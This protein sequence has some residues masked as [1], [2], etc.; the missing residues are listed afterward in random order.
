MTL[1]LEDLLMCWFSYLL[2]A[3]GWFGYFFWGHAGGKF[4]SV[5]HPRSQATVG[6]R[7]NLVLFLKYQNCI[8]LLNIKTALS[9]VSHHFR[10]PVGFHS[11]KPWRRLSFLPGI[12]L[13]IVTLHAVGLMNC[14]SQ[15]WRVHVWSKGEGKYILVVQLFFLWK[16]AGLQNFP[17]K[18]Y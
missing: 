18:L 4:Y 3:Q 6:C 10:S 5:Q 15:A 11:G 1:D 8:V 17:G 14:I 13:G 2:N 12:A 7:E 16:S 9:S